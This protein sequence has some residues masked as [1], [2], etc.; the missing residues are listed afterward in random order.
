MIKQE[1]FEIVNR[2]KSLIVYLE[3]NLE[4]FPK[5]DLELKHKLNNE[6]YDLLKKCY[7]AN[8]AV[9]NDR[10]SELQ[11][12][13][14]SMVKY[15]DF[16]VNLCYEKKIINHKKYLQIGEKLDNI[17]KYIIGWIK[18]THNAEQQSQNI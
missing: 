5:K 18:Y 10:K 9:N 16:L 14:I 6:I 17:L 11:Y 3:T 4:N 2:I 15:I 8:N 13:L 1:K 12:E 7:L